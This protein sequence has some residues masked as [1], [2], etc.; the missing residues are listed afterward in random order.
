MI[1]RIEKRTSLIF[2]PGITLGRGSMLVI[3]PVSIEGRDME[4]TNKS[5]ELLIAEAA[6]LRRR[7]AHLEQTC[8]DRCADEQRYRA[9]FESA[10]DGIVL[11]AAATGAIIEMNQAFLE[12]TGRRGDLLPGRTLWEIDAFQKTD[13][14]F[15][16]FKE[17]REQDH[18]YY[19]DLPLQQADGTVLSVEVIATAH[20]FGSE[21][22]LQYT[23]RDI[24]RRKAVEE[25]LWRS[26]SRFRALFRKAG[27]GIAMVDTSGRVIES[28]EALQKMLGYTEKEIAGRPFIDFTHVEDRETDD[29]WLQ[30]LL[31][32][33]RD[34][35]HLAIRCLKK[36]GSTVWGLLAVSV[37]PDNSGEPLYTIR[38]IEDITDRKRA[39]ETI[40]K[41]RNFYLSLIDELPNPIRR[42]AADGRS[43]YFNRAWLEFRGRSLKDELDE[44]WT[45][46]IHPDDRNRFSKIRVASFKTRSPYVTEY[47]L[48]NRK[49]E[50]RWLV[51]SARPFND[52]D[53]NFSGY[54]SSC[55]DVQDRKNV[56]E[57]LVS[58]STTDELTGLLNRRGFFS[59]AKQQMKVANR[60]GKGFLLL[61]VDLDGMKKI[62]DA[63][64]HPGGDL[65]LVETASVL[66]ELFRESD[67]IGRLGGDEFAVLALEQSAGTEEEKAILKRLHERISARNARPGLRFSLSISAGII[68][69]D[70]QKPC[71]LDDLI[72][73]AD[74]LM[75]EEKKSKYSEDDRH[76]LRR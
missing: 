37:I 19:D 26:E 42:T 48:Q 12:M 59:L 27:F 68:N 55:Y 43:D 28:N 67:I 63:L 73:H 71:S 76:R 1:I 30:E 54:I 13:A 25:E 32:R 53:G 72:S 66:K 10:R 29:N 58:L 44:P 56:E 36:D 7:I 50:Y 57:K 35:Y 17:L 21:K 75:Y 60:T 20:S 6:E 15:V 70:P 51:E 11:V 41:S 65:A 14:I 49:N 74:T 24:G 62:N 31:S 23:I 52:L 34:N 64:G 40:V 5:K 39:E 22:V 8:T 46:G 38:M 61:F 2:W 16:I 18:I 3:F 4:E 45:G 47:R 9:L 69:Y 33:K